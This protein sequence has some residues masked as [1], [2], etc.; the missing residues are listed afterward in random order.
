MTLPEAKPKRVKGLLVLLLWI[1][2]ASFGLNLIF[3][4]YNVTHGILSYDVKPTMS[5]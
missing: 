2:T 3:V 1:I 5:P 4:E